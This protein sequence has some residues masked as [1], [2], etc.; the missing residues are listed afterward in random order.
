MGD[1][2]SLDHSSNECNL[3]LVVYPGKGRI[4]EG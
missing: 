4:K 1:A 3:R 2:R